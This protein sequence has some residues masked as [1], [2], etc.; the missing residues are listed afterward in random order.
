LDYHA[1]C[2]R[3]LSTLACEAGQLYDSVQKQNVRRQ[4]RYKT[5]LDSAIQPALWISRATRLRVCTY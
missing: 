4:N 3:L 5:R 2:P 1:T